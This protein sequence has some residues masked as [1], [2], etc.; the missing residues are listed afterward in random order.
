MP[1]D[2]EGLNL[3]DLQEP[4]D[5]ALTEYETRSESR[6]EFDAHTASQLEPTPE[7]PYSARSESTVSYLGNE[8]GNMY[9]I[10]FKPGD[11][12]GD[13]SAYKLDDLVISGTYRR[14]PSVIPRAKTGT[15]SEAHLNLVT[16]RLD[17]THAEPELFN[18]RYDLIGLKG[19]LAT[20]IGIL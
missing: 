19:R 7:K 2:I 17:D 20:R 11:G 4:L 1:K 12:T 13:E 6:F 14:T 18:G 5:A 10:A 15:H 9:V 3:R 8:I 16:Q